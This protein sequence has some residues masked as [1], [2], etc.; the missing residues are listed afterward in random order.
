MRMRTTLSTLLGVIAL[1]GASDVA[2]QTTANGTATITIGQVLYINVTNTAVTFPNPTGADYAATPAAVTATS[3]Q[4][5]IDHAGNITHDVEIAS[6]ADFFDAIN[7]ANDGMKPSTHLEWSS[8]GGTSWTGVSTAPVD[9]VTAAAA[10][11][12]TGAATIDY[13][14]L[15]DHTTD[16]PDTYTLDFTYTVVAN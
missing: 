16:A 4:S 8:D 14:M 15:L 13:R 12:Y 3:G 11:L 6:S 9:V 2:A 10:G 7:V 5:V 1:L